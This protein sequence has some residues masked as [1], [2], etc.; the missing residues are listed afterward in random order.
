MFGTTVRSDF[1][2]GST[3]T[4]KGEWQ[5]KPYEERGSILTLHANET[6]TSTQMSGRTGL[7]GKPAS[8]HTVTITLSPAGKQTYVELTQDNNA[9]DEQ[10]AHSEEKWVMMLMGLKRFVE[11]Q[12]ESLQPY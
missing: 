10:L 9:D 5:G 1:R 6:L 7:W 8:V 11:S 3:I 2:E 12:P 4:W